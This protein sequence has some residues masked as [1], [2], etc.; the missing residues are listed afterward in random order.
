MY[1]GGSTVSG[2]LFCIV[3][4]EKNGREVY[5]LFFN[6]VFILQVWILWYDFKNIGWKDYIVYRWYLI[7]RFKIGYMR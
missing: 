2:V 1:Q 4:G 7:Y 6:N 3:Q 5:S